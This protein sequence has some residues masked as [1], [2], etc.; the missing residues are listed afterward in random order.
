MAGPGG[1]G[2]GGSSLAA[3]ARGVCPVLAT[4]FDETGAI[5]VDGFGQ[6]VGRVLD[7][8]VNWVMWPGFASESYKLSDSEVAA[9]RACL[10]EQAHGRRRQAVISVARHATRLAV[11]DAVAAAEE[12]ADAISLL[13]PYLLSPSRYAVTEHLGAV[14][15]AVAPLPVIVQYA[16]ALAPS[17]IRTA[18][19]TRLAAEQQNFRM[20]KIDS[21]SAGP[22]ISELL[23]EEP[24]LE[25]VVGYAGIAMIDALRQG[26]RGIQPGCSFV[27]VYQRIWQL[28]D[29]GRADEATRLHGR[30]LPYVTSWMADMELIISVEKN[31]SKQRGW[32]GSDYC[33]AP[34]RRLTPTDHAFIFRF[35]DEF[36]CLLR[37]LSNAAGR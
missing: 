37:P 24:A 19:L 27:E 21:A 4:P 2:M 10:L 29:A 31:I 15:S 28:W 30:L 14:M 16:P 6:L 5:D 22:M 18:D 3:A 32:I 35:L 1:A 36:A 23:G 17:P 13:P 9:M 12:G 20:V 7:S 25:S 11:D 8:G 33:R 26:A 34:G